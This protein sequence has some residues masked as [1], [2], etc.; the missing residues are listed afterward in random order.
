MNGVVAAISSAVV[1]RASAGRRAVAQALGDE[2]EV[3]LAVG[4][5]PAAAAATA[6]V[7]SSSSA[8]GGRIEPLWAKATRP[9]GEGVRVVRA[10][11]EA[12]RRPAQV[13]D[14]RVGAA[15]AGPAGELGAGPGRVGALADR[16]PAQRV[17][18]ATP[19]PSPCLV[20]SSA[21][22]ARS[23][24]PRRSRSVVGTR[25]VQP[26]SRHTPFTMTPGAPGSVGTAGAPARR[27]G[28]CWGR[29]RREGVLD[30]LLD[31]APGR[32]SSATGLSGRRQRRHVQR[33]GAG[34]GTFGEVAQATPEDV[35]PAG[36]AAER[37]CAARTCRA[38]GETARQVSCGGRPRRRLAR[39]VTPAPPFGDIQVHPSAQ[40]CFE[41]SVVP[42]HP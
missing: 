3:A 2:Q 29:S 25:V 36:A 35:H 33:R 10:D 6:A 4:R 21:K 16:D 1:R 18:R 14:A 20:D 23:S 34:D 26:R 30:G 40:E 12:H 32:A 38:R 9:F 17:L 37:S 7:S 27:A 42:A 5:A 28:G 11:A 19:Q 39:D 8:A 13:R 31:D 22:S 24:A 15:P 41:A